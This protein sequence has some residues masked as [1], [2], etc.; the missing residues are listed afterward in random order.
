VETLKGA[1][2]R[3]VQALH[4]KFRLSWKGLPETNTLAYYKP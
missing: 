3:L 4:A 1:L 2:L